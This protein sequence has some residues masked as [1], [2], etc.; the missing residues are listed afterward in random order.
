MFVIA[1]VV[2][3]VLWFIWAGLA[4]LRKSLWDVVHQNLLDL[5]DNY[6]G[7]II[8][9]GFAARPV[10]HGKVDGNN[11]TINF[12]TAKTNSGRKTYIDISLTVESD[13]SLTITEKKW[14]QEQDGETRKNALELATN[15]GTTY[16]IMPGDSEKVKVLTGDEGLKEVLEKF[17][18]LVYFFIGQSGAIC[19]FWSDKIDIDTK[20]ETMQPRLKQIRKLLEVLK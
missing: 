4:F 11:L 6:D 20:F 15:N 10:F 16:Y 9:N 8:R 17:E 12:S 2:V 1:A 18:N 13:F 19:E 3:F 7:K 14:Q 5:E